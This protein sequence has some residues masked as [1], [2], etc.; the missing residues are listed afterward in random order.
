MSIQN[1][2][3]KHDR[4]S[5]TGRGITPHG[6]AERCRACNKADTLAIL[7]ELASFWK[8]GTPVYPG[9]DVSEFALALLA[10]LEGGAK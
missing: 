10:R 4:Q 6:A 2:C 9:S 7:R 8:E 1:L 3:P 5:R